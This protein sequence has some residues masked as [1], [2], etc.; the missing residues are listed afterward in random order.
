MSGVVVAS[1]AKQAKDETLRK[2]IASKLVLSVDAES[3]SSRF[4]QR[5]LV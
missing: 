5:I 2:L 3:C 1:Y 4:R